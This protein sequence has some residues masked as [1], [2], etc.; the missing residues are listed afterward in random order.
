MAI[1]WENIISTVIVVVGDIFRVTVS[2]AALLVSSQFGVTTTQHDINRSLSAL[3]V[4][5]D[6]R[7][8]GKCAG[9]STEARQRDG[10]SA[11]P[12]GRRAHSLL[13]TCAVYREFFE[14]H[15]LLLPFPFRRTLVTLS[16]FIIVYL[17][18]KRQH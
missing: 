4:N 3:K 13:R 7:E 6:T 9:G 5:A 2:L 14:L 17:R 11:P 16:L 1:S 12:S 18:H 15:K 10:A 8:C